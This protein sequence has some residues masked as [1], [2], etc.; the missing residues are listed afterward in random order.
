MATDLDDFLDTVVVQAAKAVELTDAEDEELVT[1]DPILLTCA[2]FAY[3]QVTAHTGRS[4]LKNTYK[5]LY[6]DV[7]K[8][9][10]LKNTPVSSV[11]T[12]TD[13]E[14]TELVVD[15]DY[16]VNGNYIILDVDFSGY[17]QRITSGVDA[18]HY[19]LVIEYEGG[20]TS[21]EQLPNLESALAL[22]S[23]ANYNRRA[24]LGIA[25]LTASSSGFK[26]GAIRISTDR[27]QYSVLAEVEEILSP[28]VYYGNAEDWA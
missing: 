5:E 10:K 16:K 8:R 21:S 19:D 6:S 14:G 7:E 9:F 18:S 2:R 20:Y 27:A 13:D 15:T 25:L 4:F 3:A 23:A 26:G 11:T 28:L 22:Q 17:P 24:H 12:I 1:T